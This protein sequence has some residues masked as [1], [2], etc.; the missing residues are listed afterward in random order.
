MRRSIFRTL[1]GGT[2]VLVTTISLAAAAWPG[3]PGGERAMDPERMVDRLTRHLELTEEQQ[4]QAA[5]LFTQTFEES[6]EDRERVEA[7]RASLHGSAAEFDAA[8][9]QAA[10]DEIGDLTSRMVYR[11]AN[12]QASLYQMLDEEQRAEMEEFNARREHHREHFRG[13]GR[14]HMW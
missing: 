9:V 7:L 8:T 2:A 1:I 13:H 4:G 14:K 5:T 3:K 10:A 11:R 12:T 6:R